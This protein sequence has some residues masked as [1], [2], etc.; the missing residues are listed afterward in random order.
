MTLATGDEK[1]AA[2]ATST[3]DVLYVLYEHVLR[4]DPANPAW[5]E[6]DRFVLSKGHGP[7]A[8]YAVLARKGF[9]SAAELKRFLQY[10]SILGAHPDRAQV[11]GIEASTGSLGHGL[12]MAVGVAY[13]LTAKGL[14]E[15]RVIVLT[16]DAELN[17][18]SNWE[19]IMHAG[20]AGL[21]NLALVVVDN[22]SSSIRIDPIGDK[23]AAFG[24]DAVEV[25]GRNHDE[26]RA[27][28]AHRRNGPVAV[29]ALVQP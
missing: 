9:F 10:D 6:R 16:G 26:L 15:Q 17:E 1:H 27:A 8:Y 12:P 3:L 20:A 29:V 5:E 4:V 23:L 22:R 7:V 18:G 11:P 19:A 25:D 2:S 13:A 21:S 28:F 24:W 14:T